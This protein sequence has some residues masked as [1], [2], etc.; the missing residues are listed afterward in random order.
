M[1]TLAE[2]RPMPL[3]VSMAAVIAWVAAKGVD[4]LEPLKPTLPVEFQQ[5]VLPDSS[6][7]VIRVLLKVAT[8]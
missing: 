2:R 8:M 4:F 1:N 3:A 7:I 6:V 5:M